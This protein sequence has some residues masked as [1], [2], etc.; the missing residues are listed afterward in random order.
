MGLGVATLA[1]ARRQRSLHHNALEYE[2]LYMQ[3]YG[4]L[5]KM[6][7]PPNLLELPLVAQIQKIRVGA[8]YWAPK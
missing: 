6:E 3:S 7:L 1:Q 4:C 5:G 2:L 8:L